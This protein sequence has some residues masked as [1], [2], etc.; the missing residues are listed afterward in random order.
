[1]SGIYIKNL[2]EIKQMQVACK[3]AHL[4]LKEVVSVVSLGMSTLEV[5]QYAAEMMKKYSCTSAFLNYRGF[6]GHICISINEEVVHGFGKNRKIVNGDLVKIDVGI[7]KNGWFGDNAQTIQIGDRE[8]KKNLSL[9]KTTEKSLY[10][11]I[12]YAVEGNQL[13]DI[14]AAIENFIS[15]YGFGIVKELVGHGVGKNLHEEPQ[16]PNYRPLGKSP[17]LKAGMTLAIE[18]MINLGSSEVMTLEDGW[19]IVTKDKKNSAHFEHTVL[20]GR[21]KAEILTLS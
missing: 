14:C 15:P 6:P 10:E 16:I 5:D 20:V 13:F 3:L 2:S 1:M 17:I 21:S 9:I 19:T 11:G 18:P 7:K 4:V 8:D 12:S